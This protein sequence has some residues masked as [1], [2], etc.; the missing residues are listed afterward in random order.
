[1]SFLLGATAYGR[2]S[3]L[4][5]ARRFVVASSVC[6]LSYGTLVLALLLVV[7]HATKSFATAGAAS[8]AFSLCTLSGPAKA[9]FVGDDHR[10]G[11]VAILGAAY[12]GSLVGLALLADA[13]GGVAPFIVFSV[14]AGLS[15]PPVGAMTRSRWAAITTEAD[16]QRAFA[17]DV[18][19]EDGLFF[20]GPLLTGGLVAL[21]GP[22]LAM[23]V[24]AALFAAGISLLV[25]AA[26]PAAP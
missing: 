12:V 2:L 1:M 16:R 5:A 25:L 3:R 24:T 17:L 22:G 14:T 13:A 19:L 4:P 18:A 6:R 9:R 11:R 23:W 15:V 20:V 10:R 26:Q 21:D 7:E 8:A